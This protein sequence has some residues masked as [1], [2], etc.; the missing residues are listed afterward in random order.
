[1][2]QQE[3]WNLGPASARVTTSDRWARID[4]DGVL[5]A[6]A[7]ERL[8]MQI[9]HL[10]RR[11]GIDGYTLA[12]T[13]RVLRLVTNISAVE[14]ALRGSPSA[15]AAPGIL[16]VPHSWAGWAQIHCALMA[17][18]GFS[19]TTISVPQEARVS[20]EPELPSETSSH[21]SLAMTRQPGPR[22]RSPALLRAAQAP[23][24]ARARML[25]RGLRLTGLRRGRSRPAR[26]AAG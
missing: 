17:S 4:L 15:G 14:A 11:N 16:R 8:H 2:T 5:T 12:L 6:Q 13:E 24:P 25:H 7:Y 10:A 22:P 23:V 3:Y 26:Q 19:L 20:S 1:M 9:A 21:G 18:H